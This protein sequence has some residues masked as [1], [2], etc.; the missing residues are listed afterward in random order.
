MTSGVV[1][2]SSGRYFEHLMQTFVYVFT[3]RNNQVIS[4]KRLEKNLIFTLCSSGLDRTVHIKFGL[5][6]WIFGLI[7]AFILNNNNNNNN[8]N[9]TQFWTDL[10]DQTER[11]SLLEKFMQIRSQSGVWSKN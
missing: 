4:S 7:L 3:V 6:D 2:T 10:V 8:N 5:I 1:Q 9:Q 11:L